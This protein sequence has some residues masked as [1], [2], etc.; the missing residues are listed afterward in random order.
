MNKNM[1]RTLKFTALVLPLIFIF[2]FCQEYLFDYRNY[3]TL[4]IER[5]YEQEEDSLDVVLI[6]ASELTQ[7]YIPGY[8]YENYGFTNYM[9]AMDANQGSLYLSQLKEIR[10]HQ[11]PDILLVD[12]YGFLRADDT[13]L[14][15]ETRL[16]LYVEN[17][18]FSENKIETIMD[19]PCDQK[20]SYFLPLIMYHGNPSIAYGRLYNTYHALSKDA[21]PSS[22]KG[23]LTRTLVYTGNGDPGEDYDPSTYKLTERSKAYL[24]EFL[25]YCKGNGL[26]II[27][28]NFPRNLA[29]ES[30]HSL[31]F[32]LEQAE[33]IVVA[34]G[35][36]IWNLHNEMD[37]IGI[38]R[39]QDFCNE[40]HL[41]I[42]GQIKLTD[43]LCSR[44]MTECTLTPRALSERSKQEWDDCAANTKE[45]IQMAMEVIASGTDMVIHEGEKDWLYRN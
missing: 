40:H 9:Y 15:D 11:S 39:N 29:D 38:D 27:F 12:L 22:L 7:G 4:R 10:K 26:N 43:Y 36:P 41:N 20:L 13:M 42:Y 5:F 24:V 2:I 23:A 8:A 37:V 34:H 33:E 18:P 45:Y 19:H 35:Y 28:T 32:L 1:L 44:I 21:Q 17:I 6:G 3:D 14:L 31:L 25:D 30:N 16:R